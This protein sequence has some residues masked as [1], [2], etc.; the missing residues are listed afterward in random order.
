M[1]CG[2]C[3]EASA[4]WNFVLQEIILR[5]KWRAGVRFREIDFKNFELRAF[6]SEKKKLI[7]EFGVLK[8]EFV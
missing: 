8:S 7:R 1:H 5:D 2:F 4:L 6:T 3:I